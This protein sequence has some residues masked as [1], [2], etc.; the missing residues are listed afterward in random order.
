MK[1]DL[2]PIQ[3][4]GG[5][6][7]EAAEKVPLPEDFRQ[8]FYLELPEEVP[9]NPF[10]VGPCAYFVFGASFAYPAQRGL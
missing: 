9:L 4:A 6:L 8:S 2:T 3:D 1:L 5:S 10:E 7:R